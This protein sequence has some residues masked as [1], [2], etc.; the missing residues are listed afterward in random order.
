MDEKI[1]I[2]NALAKNYQNI[3]DGKNG[4]DTFKAYRDGKDKNI[5]FSSDCHQVY[6]LPIT[7]QELNQSLKDS[8]NTAP[9]ED[10]IPYEMIRQLST[11]S[12]LFILAFFNFIFLNNIFLDCWRTAIIIPILKSGKIP[13]D[14]SSYRPISLLSCLYKLLDK[15]IN[16]RL[17]H[18]LE[19]NNLL[20]QVEEMLKHFTYITKCHKKNAYLATLLV[21]SGN[22]E[23]RKV[24]KM[25]PFDS[26]SSKTYV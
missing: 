2:A 6:N 26:L 21:R 12:L 4:R 14:C 7:I 17:M 5:D 23:H 10:K 13:T 1:D 25:F 15:I 9:G 18:I 22:P 19:S 11:D 8:K 20:N 3:S 24:F 16:S